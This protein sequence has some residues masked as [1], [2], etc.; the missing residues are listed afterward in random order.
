MATYSVPIC[1]A[2]V[3]SV[4]TDPLTGVRYRIREAPLASA[5]SDRS[6]QTRTCDAPLARTSASCVRNP[7]RFASAAPLASTFSVVV[8]PVAVARLDPES[9]TLDV[10]PPRPVASN[11]VAPLPSRLVTLGPVYQTR[12]GSLV[13]EFPETQTVRRP[14]L[15]SDRSNPKISFCADTTSLGA[16]LRTVTRIPPDTAIVAACCAARVS[17]TGLPVPT[18]VDP[19][20]DDGP[21]ELRTI[22]S[23]Q[24]PKTRGN[25]R[26]E[27]RGF[28]PLL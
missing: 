2:P 10:S 16:P 24:P 18:M 12:I 13:L 28:T 21:D 6:A 17:V 4:R 14:P 9:R 5:V 22:T 27:R 26:I 8:V 20:R 11:W 15:N 1:D 3:A 23:T 19:P 7:L 25:A